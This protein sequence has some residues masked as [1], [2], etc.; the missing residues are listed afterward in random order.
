M[1]V[2]EAAGAGVGGAIFMAMVFLIAAVICLPIVLVCIAFCNVFSDKG[3]DSAN[4][5]EARP[6]PHDTYADEYR[7]HSDAIYRTMIDINTRYDIKDTCIWWLRK[8][9]RECGGDGG[10]L[11]IIG[12][13]DGV[14]IQEFITDSEPLS[15]DATLVDINSIPGCAMCETT[16]R[17][18]RHG[19]AG[20][21]TFEFKTGSGGC[22]V[23]EY[24][25]DDFHMMLDDINGCRYDLLMQNEEAGN[26]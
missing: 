18:G 16:C 15:C 23:M 17:T 14:G 6:V 20:T 24:A 4:K 25:F 21:I 13:P 12:E 11:H 7:R 10:A 22:G 1:R 5:G 19:V 9:Y 2:L 26:D 8:K 3:A